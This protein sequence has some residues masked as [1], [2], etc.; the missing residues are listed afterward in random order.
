[1]MHARVSPVATN[2]QERP[3][4][5]YLVEIFVVAL[6]AT[7]G[8]AAENAFLHTPVPLARHWRKERS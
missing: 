1:M 7:H 2:K 5:Q 6:P 4:E 3:A 8:G